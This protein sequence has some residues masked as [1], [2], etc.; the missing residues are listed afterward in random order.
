MEGTR[1]ALKV[2][3]GMV[4]GVAIGLVL[5]HTTPLPL[6]PGDTLLLDLPGGRE[7]VLAIADKDQPRQE[8]PI[9]LPDGLEATAVLSSGQKAGAV[10][11]P[12]GREISLAGLRKSEAMKVLGDALGT[13]VIRLS[14]GERKSV[15][16]LPTPTRAVYIIGELFIRLLRM[17]IVP[18]IIAT[19]L[20]GIASIGDFRRVGRVFWQ[21]FAFYV[22][23]MVLAASLGLMLMN[24]FEP[25]KGLQLPTG[26]QPS[27]LLQQAPSVSDL[28]LRIVPSNPVEA[29]VQMDVLGMLFF[30]IIL[31]LAILKA[32]KKKAA[33]V[34]NFFEGLNDLVYVIIGWVMALAPLGVGA[35]VA[36]F[37]GIQDL[38][39]LSRLLEKLGKFALLVVSGLLVHFAILSL[40]VWLLGKYNPF[41]FIKK[42]LPALVTALG[43]DSSSATLPV[44]MSVVPTAGVS[45][46][47]YGFVVPVGATANMDGTALYE[48]SAALFFAQAYGVDLGLGQQAIVVITAV[49]AAMGAAGIPSAGLITMALVLTAVGLP[50][51]GI[52]LLFAIDRPIDMVR[53]MVNVYGD[54]VTSR[55]VQTWNREIKPEE[56]DLYTEYVE[57]EPAAAHGDRV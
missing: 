12:D 17:L 51:A 24:L 3:L 46:R 33:P 4:L 7:M 29:L 16:L 19:V 47:I 26:D 15:K 52:A 48:A 42:M 23:T 8:V 31:A 35:L 28:I 36:Y 27:A 34:F 40:L 11:L 43:T 5:M 2:F 21:T 37:V 55:V 22:A 1:I 54:C 53:T 13:E 18:L 14:V 9:R 50:L 45:K 41:V 6:Q 44:T 32:G 56:D 49:L 38:E 10:R 39:S 25:G 30:T 57:I 20:V